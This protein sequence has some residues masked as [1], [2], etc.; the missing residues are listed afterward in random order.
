MLETVSK[1][2]YKSSAY[3]QIRV[4]TKDA[5]RTIS[6]TPD[7]SKREVYTRSK[8]FG[9]ETIVCHKSLELVKYIDKSVS[10]KR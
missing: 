6:N 8:V 1:F 9:V 7:D 2:E 5:S 3:E 10:Q 4:E